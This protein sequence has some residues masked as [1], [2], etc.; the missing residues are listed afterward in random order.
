ACTKRMT[1]VM[2]CRVI[3]TGKLGFDTK[4][5]EVLPTLKMRDEFRAITVEQLLASRAGMGAYKELDPR[6]TPILFDRKGN[7]VER[8][9]RF[10]AYLLLELPVVKPGSAEEFS[11][12]SFFVAAELAA[13]RTGRPWEALIQG[14][15]F[16][17]L[18]MTKS[19]FGRPR[20]KD[21]LN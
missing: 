6:L 18:G 10:L 5:A 1:S 13:R 8:R 17:P 16:K 14:E 9:N 4:L 21:R 19:G 2:V 20:S 3:D 7:V 15:I 12:A 11:N